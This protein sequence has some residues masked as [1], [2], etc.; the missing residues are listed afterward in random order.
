[1]SSTPAA[2]LYSPESNEQP[3]DEPWVETRVGGIAQIVHGADDAFAR[4]GFGRRSRNGTAAGSG[5]RS[6][7]SS[8]PDRT[9]TCDL[10]IKSPLLYQ[11]SYRPAGANV[12]LQDAGPEGACGQLHCQSRGLVLVV[13]DWI[14]LDE[15]QRAQESAFGDELHHQVR[16]PVRETAANGRPHA[17]RDIWVDDIQVDGH[18]DEWGA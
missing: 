14:D 13:E 15:L 9:R 6:P 16:L 18:M 17:R 8:G 12:A 3:T 5:C 4:T 11:L 10:G 1:M 7:I 2:L